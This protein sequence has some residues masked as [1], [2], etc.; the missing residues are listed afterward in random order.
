LALITNEPLKMELETVF[1]QL[2]SAN[3]QIFK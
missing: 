1:L 2:I 3:T